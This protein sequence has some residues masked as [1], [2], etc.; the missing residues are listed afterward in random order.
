MPH[1][2]EVLRARD[3]RDAPAA[4]GDQVLSGEPAAAEVV[5]QEAERLRVLHLRKR[6]EHGH[7]MRRQLQACARI[8]AASGDD[9]AVD[10]LR[11]ELLDVLA[12]AVGIVGA[13]AQEDRH[14]R[15]FERVLD[16]FEDGNAETAVT[17]GRDQSD[18]EAAAAQQALRQV[19]R[20]EIEPLRRP[21]HALARLFAQ[22]TRAV[23]T[24]GDRAEA[25]PCRRRDVVDG[26]RRRSCRFRRTCRFHGR[27]GRGDLGRAASMAEK[28][29][30][31]KGFP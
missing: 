17:V 7:R 25:H 1:R 13:V 31:G 29:R 6:V 30:A 22:L 11:K 24:F 9:D 18:R 10:A 2:L 8:G 21:M 28:C 23:E 14:A 3:V 4:G 27:R 15:I 16:A 20:P 26:R 12:L 19:V 5:R